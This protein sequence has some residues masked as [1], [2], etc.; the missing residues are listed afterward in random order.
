MIWEMKIIFPNVLPLRLH[1]KNFPSV[2]LYHMQI[3]YGGVLSRICSMKFYSCGKLQVK[4]QSDS[5]S[6]LSET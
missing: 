4:I 3:S 5:N 1:V 2:I 6:I